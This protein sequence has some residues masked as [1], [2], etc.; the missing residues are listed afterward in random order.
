MDVGTNEEQC[1]LYAPS[2]LIANAFKLDIIKDVF[3]K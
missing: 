3:D 1:F 2:T